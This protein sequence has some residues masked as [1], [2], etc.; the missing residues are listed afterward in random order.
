LFFLATLL[1]VA[2]AQLPQIRLNAVHPQGGTV[3]ATFRVAV[4]ESTD[5][6]ELA[7]MLFSDPGIV[8]VPAK[9]D[10]GAAVANAFDVTIGDSVESGYYE[11][12]LRG[13]FGVSN[14][15][16][17]RVD[18]LP[19]VSE[20]EPNNAADV[21]QLVTINQIVNARA[22]AAGDVDTYKVVIAAGQTITIRTEAARIDSLMQPV[23]QVLNEGGRRIK[24]A[25]RILDREAS[26][27]VTS[28][29]DQTLTVKIHDVVYGGGQAY[30]YRLTVD[31]RPLIDFVWP[32]VVPDGRQSAVVL[33]GRYLPEG[34]PTEL[35]INGTKLYRQPQIIDSI[36]AT[37]PSTGSS[38]DASSVD[39]QWWNGVNGNILKLAVCGNG[40]PI[41][42]DSAPIVADG[43]QLTGPFTVAG[44]FRER[45][46]D[47]TIRFSAKQGE[48][49]DIEVLSQRLGVPANSILYVEQITKAEDG[50]E[51]VKLLATEVDGRQNPG[52]KQLPTFTTDSAWRLTAPAD[53]LYQIRV[54][55]RFAGSR[56]NPDRYFIVDV[57]TPKPDYELI[58]FESIASA[59]GTLPVTTGAV[60]IRRGGHYELP[61]YVIREGGHNAAITVTAANLPAGVTC[62]PAVIPPGKPGTKLLLQAADDAAEA[63]VPIQVVGTSGDITRESH[64]ATLLHGGV[65]GLP[66]AG[67]LTH[68]LLLNVM[69]DNQPFTVK[70]GLAEAVMHQDQQLLVPVTL[71]R[72]DGFN[73]KVDVAFTGQPANVDVP[74]VSFAPDVTTATARLFFKENAAVGPTQ[75][76]AYA[77]GPVK[78][79]RNPWMA[80]RAHA[81]VA[82]LQK[83]VEGQ[84]KL[85]AE[86]NVAMEA[87]NTEVKA[88]A[89][90][91]GALK[92]Q[93]A[94]GQ[95]EIVQLK[96]AITLAAGDQGTA[97][98]AIQKLQQAQLTAAATVETTEIPLDALTAASKALEVAAAELAQVTTEITGKTGQLRTAMEKT[99]GNVEQQVAAQ[100]GLASLQEKLK[101]AQAV[102]TAAQQKQEQLTAK[103]TKAD[104]AA[105]AA[106]EATKA[107]DVTV[108]SVATTIQLDVFATPGKI[109]AVVPGGGVIKRGASIEVPV[110]IVRKNEFA[111]A[112]DVTLIVSE[113]S[114]VSAAAISIPA[115]QTQ[116]KITIS[117][118]AEA[119]VADLANAVIRATTSDFKGRSASFDVPVT[120]KVSE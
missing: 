97:L 53:G 90:T 105:K 30:S 23:I 74:A 4:T 94:T 34:E 17:F 54:R 8:A 116:G 37:G 77:T 106:D 100:A 21:A 78:Y 49:R 39:T 107:K 79:R 104:E 29:R 15:R 18:T 93:L 95:A 10:V 12:R 101:Q 83:Q 61:V 38:P 119:A 96:D 56:A 46:Q 117:A 88:T 75:L 20:A 84:Q 50:S 31:T 63:T 108:R 91:I 33:Y 59:D 6:D 64:V 82:E 112:V 1:P 120:L 66:R 118:S 35:E 43:H 99:K 70:F 67:K 69:K 3:G 111:A 24:Q 7:E 109:T 48:V 16:T 72:R 81:T 103:K 36:A 32:P 5:A 55:D 47:V 25:R 2:S 27:V 44:R 26:L 9:N 110:T 87:V 80:E 45:G 60:S 28:D 76:M 113:A 114:G 89:A 65:N 11:V 57:L 68:V 58:A 42:R 52:A 86:A 22:D 51:T 98:A 85:V 102:V 92:Q 13:L 41:Y 73:G 40:I 14:P 115:D 62:L 19:E 71:T